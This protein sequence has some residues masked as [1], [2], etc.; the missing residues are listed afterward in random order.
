MIPK[1]LRINFIASMISLG[2]ACLILIIP[3]T[4]INGIQVI[5]LQPLYHI[6]DKSWLLFRSLVFFVFS[7]VGIVVLSRNAQTWKINRA[8]KYFVAVMALG[9]IASLIVFYGFSCCESPVIFYMGFPFSW[10]RGITHAQYY[11]PLPA[12]QYLIMNFLHIDWYIDTFSLVTN[13]LFWYDI[14]LL[15]I[16]SKQQSGLILQKRKDL[17]NIK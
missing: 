11:L 5:I 2:L 15:V 4:E 13:I 8:L 7:I 16:F 14:S 9:L 10:L 6:L 3:I 12:F 1:P 17:Q